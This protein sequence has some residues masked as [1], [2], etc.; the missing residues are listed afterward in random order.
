M[1]KNGKIRGLDIFAIIKL[2]QVVDSKMQAWKWKRARR[3]ALNVATGS[4]NSN[5][6]TTN[7]RETACRLTTNPSDAIQ[8]NN[9]AEA[10]SNDR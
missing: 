2:Y 6:V 8:R 10:P 1:R 3:A 7:G 9:P 5:V 4:A